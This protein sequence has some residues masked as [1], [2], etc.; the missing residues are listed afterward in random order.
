VCAICLGLAG[1][2][3]DL[4]RAAAISDYI[5]YGKNQALI[6]IELYILSLDLII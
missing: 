4:G 3:K 1:K 6:E 2:P 5:K